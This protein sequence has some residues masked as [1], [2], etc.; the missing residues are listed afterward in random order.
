MRL[1][2]SFMSG[3]QEL[4]L[5]DTASDV[6]VRMWRAAGGRVDPLRSLTW[7]RVLRRERWAARLAAAALARRS[8]CGLAPV[9]PLPLEL[10]RAPDPAAG[11]ELDSLGPA[12]LARQAGGIGA[13]VP[14]RPDYD[15]TFA[16]WL[17]ES[18]GRQL[19]PARLEHRL[20]KRRGRAIG[21]FVYANEPSGRATL[22]ELGGRERN[23]DGVA[24]ALF[25]S[26]LADG[27]L[28]LTGRV[29]PHLHDALRR[30]R[31]SVGPGLTAVA[32][33]R[34]PELLCDLGSTDSLCSRLVGEWW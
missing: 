23:V 34:D 30:H 6:V 2:T 21:W 12:E 16:A 3:A 20:V 11:I 1:L 18:A 25:A 15:D 32:H 28:V 8:G 22:L 29:E 24:D 5:S 9:R 33:A 31:C 19:H 10:P 27:A 7:M 17:F 13:R 14:L 26:A 4:S